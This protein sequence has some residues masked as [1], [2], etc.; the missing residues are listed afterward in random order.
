MSAVTL[1]CTDRPMPLYD[2]GV[3]RV[4]TSSHGGYTVSIETEGFSVRE[5]SYY[6]PAVDE[7]GLDLKPCQYELNLRATREDAAELRAYLA[8]N[9][10]PGE[11]AELWHLWVGPDREER[12]PR[13]RGKLADLDGETLEQFCNPPLPRPRTPWQCR[14]IIEI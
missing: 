10:R 5:N 7:L 6:R 9:L 8:K 11:T 4:E 3:R 12:M 1:L 2:S 13:F 14:M